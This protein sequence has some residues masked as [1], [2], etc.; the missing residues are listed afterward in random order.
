MENI[1]KYSYYE[2]GYRCILFSDSKNGKII[3]S[4][5]VIVSFCISDVHQVHIRKYLT[6]I[7]V[8]EKGSGKYLLVATE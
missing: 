1:S 7:G 6:L 3:L 5:R 8:F 4:T 2:L